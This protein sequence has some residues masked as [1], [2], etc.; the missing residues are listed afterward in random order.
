[1]SRL[2]Y[3][4]SLGNHTTRATQ[5][6]DKGAKNRTT[7]VQATLHEPQHDRPFLPARAAQPSRGA[8]EHH[9]SC[10]A[11]SRPRL[12]Q[13]A[14]CAVPPAHGNHCNHGPLFGSA[15]QDTQ[16]GARLVWLFCAHSARIIAFG[17]RTLTGFVGFIW[18]ALCSEHGTVPVTSIPR[19]L[20][21]CHAVAALS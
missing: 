11:A 17:C 14:V 20:E 16:H 12:L 7:T 9:R 1:M 19:P 2:P 6:R 21:W 8:V 15:A 5:T 10:A 4:I 13:G 18:C 3:L